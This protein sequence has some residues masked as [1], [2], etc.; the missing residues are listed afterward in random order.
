MTSLSDISKRL[1]VDLNILS[2]IDKARLACNF[3]APSLKD[4][5]MLAIDEHSVL[6]G[7]NYVTVV[8][9]A[10][11]RKLL[12]ICKGHKKADLMPFFEKLKEEVEIR[13]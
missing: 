8:F 2:A 11:T 4:V 5:R 13:H 9:D 7:H 3:K 6:R 1:G 10:I 12:Y